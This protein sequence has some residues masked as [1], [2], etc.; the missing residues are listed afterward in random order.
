MRVIGLMGA[1]G[2]GKDTFAELF[3]ELYGKIW[4]VRT[5]SFS[6][7]LAEEVIEAFPGITLEELMTPSFRDSQF[8][9]LRLYNCTNQKFREIALG[10]LG[11]E[12]TAETAVDLQELW[13]T[14]RQVMQWWG[15]D[16]RRA[17]NPDYWVNR[18]AEVLRELAKSRQ[19]D[20]AII[21]NVRF[22]NEWRLVVDSNLITLVGNVPGIVVKIHNRHAENV[23]LASPTGK[24][25]S[26]KLWQTQSGD[27][28]VENIHGDKITLRSQ[29]LKLFHRIF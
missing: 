10:I 12:F 29:I 3:T 20:V 14:P 2:A 23:C 16:Y 24:H 27:Y 5:L 28:V 11:G 8:D 15:T 19:C 7:A 26:E 21:T 22:M 9:S 17:E 13:L 4:K 6:A 1:K 18:M 25:D